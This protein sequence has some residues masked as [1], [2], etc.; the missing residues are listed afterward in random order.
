MANLVPNKGMNK[1]GQMASQFGM[2]QNLKE[3]KLA[4]DT[5]REGVQNYADTAFNQPQLTITKIDE[6]LNNIYPDGA[7][8]SI[9]AFYT[10][11]LGKYGR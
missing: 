4:T 5:M 1:M 3:Q 2:M 8:P 10:D 7:D 9:K 11:I 6:M